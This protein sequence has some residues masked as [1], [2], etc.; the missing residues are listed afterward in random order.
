MINI[1]FTGLISL[2]S[3]FKKSI[4]DFEILKK[5]KIVNQIILS[6]WVGE[7]DKYKGLRRYLN[8]NDIEII[9]SIPPTNCKGSIL[10]QMKAYYHLS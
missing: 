6:T 1:I 8:E 3:R 7:L 2:E 4:K 9:E 10:Y 5:N